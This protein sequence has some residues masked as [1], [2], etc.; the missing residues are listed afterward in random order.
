M[1]ELILFVVIIVIIYFMINKKEI[2][3]I[4]EVSYKNLII[5]KINTNN[6]NNRDDNELVIFLF[7]IQDYY[8]YNSQSYSEMINH[9]NNFLITYDD[10]IDYNKM[11]NYNYQ[12]LLDQKK[13]AMND[14]I[15][16]LYALPVNVKYDNKLKNATKKLSDIL[17]KYLKKIHNLYKQRMC[18]NLSNETFIMYDKEPYPNNVYDDNLFF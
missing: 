14:L 18:S 6:N 9:I 3:N 5:P 8:I 7:T 4:T 16:I 2:E 10:T 11:V 13:L 12:I 17:D 15:S 1:I